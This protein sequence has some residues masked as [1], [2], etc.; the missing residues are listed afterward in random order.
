MGIF[1]YLFNY[2]QLTSATGVPTKF[3]VLAEWAVGDCATV[4]KI[5]HNRLR[6]YR[7]NKRR[8]FFRVSLSKAVEIVNEAVNNIGEIRVRF[9][10]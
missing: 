5:V 6:A 7:V 3:E 8:E 4:E 1:P 2:T 9:Q 10:Q